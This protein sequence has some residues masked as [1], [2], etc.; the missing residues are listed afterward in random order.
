MWDSLLGRRVPKEELELTL[1]QEHGR[2]NL[3]A[4][5]LELKMQN[6][7]P[8]LEQLFALRTLEDFLRANSATEE[9]IMDESSFPLS[10]S[11]K[12]EHRSHYRS[13]EVISRKINASMAKEASADLI[14]LH[15]ALLAHIRD[16]DQEVADWKRR[17]MDGLLDS[18]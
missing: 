13:L 9:A 5:A 11:H 10:K 7:A 1:D 6:G 16:K 14:A 18:A 12:E 8:L 2:I 3:L 4:F 15:Q 17:Q